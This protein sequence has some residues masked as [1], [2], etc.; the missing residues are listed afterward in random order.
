MFLFRFCLDYN[1]T[2]MKPAQ[3]SWDPLSKERRAALLR[4]IVTYFRTEQD[5]DIGVIAAE[6]ILDF[7]LKNM[8]GD[9]YKKAIDDVKF[10]IKQNAENLEVDLDLLIQK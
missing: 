8:S 5:Q 9:L 4:E 6:E 10:L 3:K 2:H 7:F 1:E